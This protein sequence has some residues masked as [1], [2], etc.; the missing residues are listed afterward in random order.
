ML[1]QK[2]AKISLFMDYK[3]EFNKYLSK[4]YLGTCACSGLFVMKIMGEYAIIINIED[5]SNLNT[6]EI[7]NNLL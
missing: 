2:G 3:L 1:T 6:F 5:F 4:I 7:D